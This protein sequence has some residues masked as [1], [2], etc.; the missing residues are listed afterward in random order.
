MIDS[1]ADFSLGDTITGTNDNGV[2]I[3]SALEGR[4]Y[5]FPVTEAVATAAG[6][7]NRAVGRRVVARIVRNTSGS[8]LVAGEIV[9]VNIAGGHAKLGQ[10]IEAR[11]AG[12][13][14]RCCLVCDPSLGASTVADD[15][16]FYAI[17][18]GPTKIK[19]PASPVT[20]ASGDQLMSGAGGRLDVVD[21]SVN[22]EIIKSLGT[23]VQAAS[24]T[25]DELVEVEL[26]P[27]W[28]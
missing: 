23:V 4:E 10:L 9:A 24:T 21:P 7:S 16:L 11:T 27:E 6:M 28:V 20:L 26:A 19:Q 13:G 18:A 5:T 15:D 14:D 25:G 3:N 8:A 2:L 12:T 22:G 1:V 17:V